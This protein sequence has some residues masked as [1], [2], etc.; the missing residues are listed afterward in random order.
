[1]K[2]LR[3]RV[4]ETNRIRR[5]RSLGRGGWT[6]PHHSAGA[7]AWR[8]A[9]FAIVSVFASA[10]FSKRSTTEAKVAPDAAVVARPD[11]SSLDEIDLYP[12]L[13][14][15][16]AMTYVDEGPE[17]AVDVPQEESPFRRVAYKIQ[18]RDTLASVLADFGVDKQEVHALASASKGL[19]SFS[20]LRSGET[21]EFEVLRDVGKL[22]A[23]RYKISDRTT[24]VVSREDDRL[25]GRREEL[26]TELRVVAK[27]GEISTS[28]YE[29]ALDAGVEA[30]IVS[31]LA[32]IFAW[33]IDFVRDIRAG[34]AFQVLYEERY[35]EDRPLGAGRI[36]AATFTNRGKTLEAY[37]FPD[38]RGDW[39]FFA[40]DGKGLGK[41]Y[42][43]APLEYTRISSYFT[44]ARF[45]PVL[46]I[47]MPHMGVDFA[48]PVGTPVRAVG[49]GTISFAGWKG[50]NGKLVKMRHN[51][52]HESAYAHLSRIS[53]GIRPGVKV[54]KGQ[55]VGYVG[56]T[57]RATGPHLHYAFYV[58]G[59]YV[60]PLKMKLA[61]ADAVAKG[62]MTA[63]RK[64]AGFLQAALVDETAR[65]TLTARLGRKSGLLAKADDGKV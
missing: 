16:A 51:S 28:L 30:G 52:Q 42:L 37:G 32:D 36:L 35:H 65:A 18:P 14:A 61:G 11:V 54:H 24:L 39:A 46:G 19:F 7:W 34:D 25:V 49:E 26:E 40:A 23:F 33:E 31:Q 47:K 64:E 53:K 10:A 27:A 55:V 1:M 2:V 62:R 44:S 8:L 15:F 59:R 43:R 4:R 48:A 6:P 12:D 57:G 22:N 58:G 50:A 63:F 60:N 38:E 21:V 17:V 29:A 45:H 56:A 3:I 41:Q 20:K 9:I 5:R 13:D